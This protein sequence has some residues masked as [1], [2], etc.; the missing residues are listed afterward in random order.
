MPTRNSFT[1]KTT[2]NLDTFRLWDKG[3]LG[4][5][6]VNLRGAFVYLEGNCHMTL[7]PKYNFVASEEGN[8]LPMTEFKY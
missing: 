7:Q 3:T 5:L 1:S 6:V 2:L 8:L 4:I